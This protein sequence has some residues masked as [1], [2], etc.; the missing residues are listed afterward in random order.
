MSANYEAIRKAAV[1]EVMLTWA[2]NPYLAAQNHAYLF[3]VE[4]D[5]VTVENVR[6]LFGD[7][8]AEAWLAVRRAKEDFL[9]ASGVKP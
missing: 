8:A 7:K 5:P 3:N 9:K 1:A 2:L 6:G 4:P